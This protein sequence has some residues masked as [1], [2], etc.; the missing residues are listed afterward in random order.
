MSHTY[1]EN[2]RDSREEISDEE[3]RVSTV[4]K[5][6]ALSLLIEEEALYC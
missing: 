6:E 3:Y 2:M 1:I 4:F 5:E